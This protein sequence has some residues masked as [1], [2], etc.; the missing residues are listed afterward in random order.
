MRAI[1]SI[2][3]RKS[4]LFEY[5]GCPERC[6]MFWIR[7]SELSSA[8]STEP[9]IQNSVYRIVR[10]LLRIVLPC[11]SFL[12]HTSHLLQLFPLSSV[13]PLPRLPQLSRSLLLP[14]IRVRRITSRA[15]NDRSFPNI[16]LP[17]HAQITRRTNIR[18]DFIHQDH[19][20]ASRV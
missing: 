19:L 13:S 7:R 18:S 20:S 10:T 14:L 15:E 8:Q 4:L 16:S 2:T 17:F 5:H 6:L 11:L 3:L 1:R 9:L 12:N